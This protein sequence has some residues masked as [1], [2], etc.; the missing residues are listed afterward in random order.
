[1]LVFLQNTIREQLELH[2]SRVGEDHG[3]GDLY[4]QVFEDAR[5]SRMHGFGL[6]VGG[7]NCQLLQ[8]A[9]GA[10]RDAKEENL[11]LRTM[12]SHMARY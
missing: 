1:M 7:K 4:S 11:E 9:I 8:Q 10:L 2:P 3:E 6:L 5:K 12:I